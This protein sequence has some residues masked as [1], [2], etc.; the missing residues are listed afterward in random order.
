MRELTLKLWEVELINRLDLS[1]ITDMVSINHQYLYELEYCLV[2]SI[3]FKVIAFFDNIRTISDIR[4]PN[5]IQ[6][7]K[8]KNWILYQRHSSH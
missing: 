7:T 5:I 1:F 6:E 2:V 8:F 3:V 4:P